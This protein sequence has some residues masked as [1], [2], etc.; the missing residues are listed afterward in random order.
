MKGGYV[1]NLRNGDVGLPGS[2][3]PAQGKVEQITK[4]VGND[5]CAAVY[6]PGYAER[7]KGEIS[8][9]TEQ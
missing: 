7:L 1:K 4:E 8:E 6:R 9:A 5:S 3:S 2:V